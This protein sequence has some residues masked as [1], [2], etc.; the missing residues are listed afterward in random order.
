MQIRE[1]KTEGRFENVVYAYDGAVT[2]VVVVVVAVVV[3]VGGA[4]LSFSSWAVQFSFV[5]NNSVAN[6]FNNTPSDSVCVLSSYRHSV[7]RSFARSLI[8]QLAT[9]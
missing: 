8:H 5:T 1:G 3:A 6:F 7:I 2:V 4:T 9:H